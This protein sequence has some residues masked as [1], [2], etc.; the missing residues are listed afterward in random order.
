MI[1][2]GV[3]LCTNGSKVGQYLLA[4]IGA[5]FEPWKILKYTAI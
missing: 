1:T 3:R 4:Y 5:K 2:G